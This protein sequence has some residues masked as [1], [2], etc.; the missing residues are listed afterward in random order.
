MMSESFPHRV[1]ILF[2]VRPARDIV[3]PLAPEGLS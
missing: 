2:F 3:L 1:N